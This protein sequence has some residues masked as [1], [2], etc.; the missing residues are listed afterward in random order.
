MFMAQAESKRRGREWCLFLL[1]SLL[2]NENRNI[3]LCGRQED[4]VYVRD[5]AEANISAAGLS[6]VFQCCNRKRN[7]VNELLEKIKLLLNQAQKKFMRSS[8]SE[9]AKSCWIQESCK[10]QDGK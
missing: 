3:R 9:L 7:S 6:G 4:Y 1:A 5:V 8:C 2:N 10:K